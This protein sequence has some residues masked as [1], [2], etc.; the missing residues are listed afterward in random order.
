MLHLGRLHLKFEVSVQNLFCDAFSKKINLYVLR[1]HNAMSVNP[2][3]YTQTLFKV[4]E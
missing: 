3:F 4:I 1:K 2:F